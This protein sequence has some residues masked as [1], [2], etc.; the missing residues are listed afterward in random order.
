MTSVEVALGR[1]E[2]L[3]NNLSRSMSTIIHIT[4]IH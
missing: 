2:T 4:S 3:V 1:V